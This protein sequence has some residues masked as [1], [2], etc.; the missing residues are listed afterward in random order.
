MLF[1]LFL[2]L[3][4]LLTYLAVLKYN[5]DGS[6]RNLALVSLTKAT[7]L[8]PGVGLEISTYQCRLE[9]SY[10]ELSCLSSIELYHPFVN[11][12]VLIAIQHCDTGARGAVCKNGHITTVALPWFLPHPAPPH[13]PP[14][15]CTSISN[16]K[17]L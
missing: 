12:W 16:S 14:T 2:K 11:E 1:P 4:Y 3:C 13:L 8:V 17:P 15:P 7:E 6:S 10:L 9:V 5:Q